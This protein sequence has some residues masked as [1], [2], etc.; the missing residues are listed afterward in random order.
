MAQKDFNAIDPVV[1]RATLA[2]MSGEPADK[3]SGSDEFAQENMNMRAELDESRVQNEILSKENTLLKERL[4]I[5]LQASPRQCLPPVALQA[6]LNS[7][8]VPMMFS[9]CGPM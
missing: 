6:S 2:T 1:S 3:P 7:R 9:E 4:A 8:R 5:A